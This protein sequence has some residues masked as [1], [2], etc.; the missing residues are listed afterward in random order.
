LSQAGLSALS[1][2]GSWGPDYEEIEIDWNGLLEEG[3]KLVPSWIQ[4]PQSQ[5]L[6]KRPTYKRD[7]A[8]EVISDL[9]PQGVPNQKDL[10][11]V[12]L[13]RTVADKIAERRRQQRLKPTNISDDT[14]LRAAGRLR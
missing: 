6:Q 13:C 5:K 9:W 11:N 12:E 8:T 3:R 1:Q 4:V 14:I 7:Q 10:S 2:V